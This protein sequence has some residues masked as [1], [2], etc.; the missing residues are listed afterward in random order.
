MEHFLGLLRIR[1]LRG[2]NL[3][4]RDTRSSDPFVVVT[5]GDTVFDLIS[6]LKFS[7]IGEIDGLTMFSATIS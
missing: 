6:F 3:A 4:V 5:M 1:V 7:V 2:S